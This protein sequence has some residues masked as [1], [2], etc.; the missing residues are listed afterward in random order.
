MLVKP[1]AKAKDI[2][3]DHKC[4][5][6]EGF[7]PVWRFSHSILYLVLSFGS[8]LRFSEWLQWWFLAFQTCL[9]FQ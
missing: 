7:R 1:L 4:R 8:L 3:K 5:L 9:Q 6:S 2:G